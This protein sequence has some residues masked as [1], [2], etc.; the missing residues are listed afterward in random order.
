[1]PFSCSARSFMAALRLILTRPLSSMPMHLA[2]TMSPFLTT[3][4]TVLTR[5]SQSSEMVDH[6]ILAGE[7]FHEGAEV[8]RGDDFAEVDLTDLDLLGDAFHHLLGAQKAFRLGGID[9]HG[10][11]VLDG[12]FRS[13]TRPESP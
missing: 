9:E 4:S 1:V 13:G 7:H 8:G 6:P 11:V 2:Q 3:S 5:L 10:A 12:D